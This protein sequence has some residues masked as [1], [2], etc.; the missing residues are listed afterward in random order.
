[1]IELNIKN[2]LDKNIMSYIVGPY[3]A[4]CLPSKAS[5]KS[6]PGHNLIKI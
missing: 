6:N 3:K 5:S 1:M 4:F 2:K